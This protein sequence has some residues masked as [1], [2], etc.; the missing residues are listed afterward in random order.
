VLNLRFRATRRR[1]SHYNDEVMAVPRTTPSYSV[2]PLTRRIDA[3]IRPPGS[4]S[5]TNRALLL[6]GLAD[7]TSTLHGALFS[8]DTLHMARGLATLGLDV[9]SDEAARS[10]TIRGG[11]GKIPA[12]RASVFV[13]NS[14][15]TARFLAPM[16]AL[17]HGV[18]ELDGNEAMRTRPIQP[19]L[20][21]MAT[22][23][24]R[25]KS[26]AGNGCLPI[27]V[28]GGGFEGGSA[29]MP[30][31]VSSQYFSGL[32]M[33]APRLP[34]GI[35]LDV[36]GDLV[37]KPYLEVTAQAM[38]AFGATMKHTDFRRFEVA[39]GAYTAT[40]YEVEPDASAA[41]YFF[42]A[43]AVTGGRVVVTGLGKSSLQGDLAFVK[44]LERMG[45]EVRQTETQ[46]EVIGP[47][48]L[49]GIEADMASMSDTAQTLAAIAPFATSPTRVTGIGFIRKKETNRIA[50]VVTEL[51]KLG[52]RAEE[53]SDGFVVFPSA[54]RPGSVAT[55]D[56][57][58]MAMSFALVGL[59]AHGIDILNPECVSKTFPHYFAELEKL[60]DG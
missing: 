37:S 3:T 5:Y 29:R 40:R 8:D 54:P 28:E 46:T 10:F 51:Q 27:R 57:H 2:R 1:V 47:S 17:G 32:L 12:A 23:G 56:D 55:Y 31:A 13:G 35:V 43:A 14:G 42:A 58:R 38:R 15:T 48:Q 26:L 25:A 4:K 33:V 60:S 49:S 36:D 52:V 39:P 41:S 34:R 18:Y 50:A 9:V 11:G 22:L 16:L 53:E 45:C 24:A 19:L 44:L 30:G 6:A 7:G 59:V 21:A 20:D